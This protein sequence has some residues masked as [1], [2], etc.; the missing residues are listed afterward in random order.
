MRELA[1]DNSWL[2]DLVAAQAD[3]AEEQIAPGARNEFMRQAI[4]YFRT[5]KRID[6]MGERLEEAGVYV[7]GKAGLWAEACRLASETESQ[8][9]RG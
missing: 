9:D 4:D 3:V 7:Y 6:A 8:D 1:R 5:K 2:N